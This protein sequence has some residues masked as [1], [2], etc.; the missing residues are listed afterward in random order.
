MIN[1]IATYH[2]IFY[3]YLTNISFIPGQNSFLYRI[4]PEPLGS[5]YTRSPRYD[6]ILTKRIVNVSTLVRTIRFQNKQ[7]KR[8][9]SET[10]KRVSNSLR[11][12]RISRPDNGRPP[13]VNPQ[14][15]LLPNEFSGHGRV[16]GLYAI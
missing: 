2:D 5:K 11:V 16:A 4:N 3:Q 6:L 9:T 13:P 10:N 15:L 7:K 1:R 12:W 8:K 14:G